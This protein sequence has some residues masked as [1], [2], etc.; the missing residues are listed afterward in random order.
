MA[1]A[2]ERLQE[3]APVAEPA[4]E[5]APQAPS[6]F[7]P[8]RL[9]PA[10]VMAMQRSAGN[11]AVTQLLSRMTATELPEL[12]GG[13]LAARLEP[14]P[15]RGGGG[16]AAGGG[17]AGGPVAAG[18]QGAGAGSGAGATGPQGAGAGG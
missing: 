1:D 18:P 16:A 11:A 14:R 9:S 15:V 4:V 6:P 3:A 10:R 2:P 17:G 12:G 8:G 5:S 7:G 13:D